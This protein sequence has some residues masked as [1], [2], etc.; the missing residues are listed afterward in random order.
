MRAKRNPD[1]SFDYEEIRYRL[2]QRSG[3]SLDVVREIDRVVIGRLEIK[4]ATSGGPVVSA[5]PG[6]TLPEVVDAICVLL[7]EPLGVLRL[8]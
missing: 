2:E 8:Q 3:R 5:L 1:G 6:A 7:A 4:S